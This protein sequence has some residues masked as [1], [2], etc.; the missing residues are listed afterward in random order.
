VRRLA[1]SLSNVFQFNVGA[2]KPY[3]GLDPVLVLKHGLHDF[4]GRV[5]VNASTVH[6]IGNAVV[7]LESSH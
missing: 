4:H 3:L 6:D 2:I 1:K 7:Y 5:V